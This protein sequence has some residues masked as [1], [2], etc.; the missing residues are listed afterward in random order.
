MLRSLTRYWYSWVIWFAFCALVSWRFGGNSVGS[1][2][3][4]LILV[5]PIVL[6]VARRIPK[7]PPEQDG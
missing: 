1:L 5:V 6:W 7:E 4:F 2:G 3:V